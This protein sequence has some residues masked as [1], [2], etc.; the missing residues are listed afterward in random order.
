MGNWILNWEIFGG[1]LIIAFI[2]S[3]TLSE[4]DSNLGFQGNAL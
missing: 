4:N 2:F 1:F 3:L